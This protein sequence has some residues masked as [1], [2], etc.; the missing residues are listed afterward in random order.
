M[1][2]RG[3]VHVKDVAEASEWKSVGKP[4]W[5]SVPELV[6]GNERYVTAEDLLDLEC[7]LEAAGLKK[8]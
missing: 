2:Q 1:W 7:D 3:C 8:R 5:F 6:E 4:Y